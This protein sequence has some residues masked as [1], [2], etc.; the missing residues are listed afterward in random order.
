M[1]VVEEEVVIRASS[2]S[3]ER[4]SECECMRYIGE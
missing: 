4:L 1:V 2:E 3:R